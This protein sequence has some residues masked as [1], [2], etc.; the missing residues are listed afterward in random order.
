L[1]NDT[2][3]GVST[4]NLIVRPDERGRLFEIL[5][6]DDPIFK[7]FGQVYIT[8]ASPGIVKAWH[9]HK[10]QTDYFCCIMGQARLVLFD[11]R[12]G[13][14]TH[15]ALREFILGPDNLQLV[16]IPPRVY[17]GF[18]CISEAEAVMINIPSEPYNSHKPDE[19]RLDPFSSE[20][21]YSWPKH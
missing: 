15:G 21:P 10:L 5:R 9:Y 7:K 4:K 14:P 20:V 2:I 18:Q 3:D 11:P 16:M 13:S 8:T 19:Y 17:H 1:R 6:A 12:P